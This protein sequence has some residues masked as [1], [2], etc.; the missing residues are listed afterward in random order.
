MTGGT[1]TDV[2]RLEVDGEV[3]A[4]AEFQAEI[5]AFVPGAET[6][7][8]SGVVAREVE[9]LEIYV[10][11]TREFAKGLVAPNQGTAV[12]ALLRDA[13]LWALV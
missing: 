7:L 3:F 8:G 11:G 1:G 6:V 5:N 13:D 12:A 9:R 10:D 2:L 4:S